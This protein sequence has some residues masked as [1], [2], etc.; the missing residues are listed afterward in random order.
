MKRHIDKRRYL[1]YAMIALLVVFVIAAALLLISL[2]DKHN[3]TFPEQTVET[4]VIYYNGKEYT[5]RE[6]TESFLLIGLDK[7]GDDSSADSYNNNK[8]ADFIML[9]V[10]DNAGKKCTP[11]QINRDTMTKVNILGVAGD[12]ID[13]ATKQIALA[14]TYGNGKDVSCR[15]VA[16]AV[17]KLLL[18]VKI[19]HYAS[20]TM[21]AVPVVTDLVGGVT[22]KIE[23]DF[24]GI[25][26]T[27]VMGDTVKLRGDHALNFVRSRYGLEDSSNARR[28]ERQR[29]YLDSLKE[30]FSSC[31]EADSSFLADAALKVSDYLISDRSVTQLE[32]LADKMA[33]Y[34][35]SEILT[36]DGEYEMGEEY[37]EYNADISSIEEIVI[38]TFYK[39]KLSY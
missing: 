20:V 31:V 8:Q 23:D 10:F 13:E 16:D 14:H 29:A 28:M 32:K 39:E 2:W 22:V 18:G 33:T 12:K 34:E 1:K 7:F 17:S 11:I 37:L 6:N 30:N 24:T 19:D 35:F 25:D 38:N 3:D 27:L 21:D 36:L 26:D 5:L 9:F 15:N 4:A